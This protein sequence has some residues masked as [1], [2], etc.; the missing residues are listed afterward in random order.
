MNHRPLRRAI[1]L[2]L[3]ALL[4]LAGTASADRLFADGDALTP[5]IEG[6]KHLGDVSPGAEV[7]VDI[8]FVLTCIGN[9]HVDDGQSVVLSANGG[10]Q[11]GDGLIVEVTTAVLDPVPSGWADDGGGCPDPVP[12]LPGGAVSR[13][14]LR[15]PTAPGIGYSFTVAWARSFQPAGNGDSLALG[16]SMTSI[17]LTMN[18][19][20]NIAPRL[21]LPASFSVEGNAVNGWTADWSGVLAT[22]PEDAPDP[23]PT[24]TPASGSTLPLGTNHVSCSVT[25]SG[26]LTTTGGFDVTVVDTTDPVL[27]G[28]PADSEVITSDPTGTTLAFSTPTAT[29]V[30]DPSP[31]VACTPATGDHVGTGTTTVTCT[32]TDASGNSATDTFDVTVT[33]RAA[34]TASATW[35]DPIDV[36]G[37]T[38]S[39]NHGRTLPIKVRLFVDG[40]EVLGGSAS[41]TVTPCG[42]GTGLELPLV[43]GGGRWNAS[44]DTSLLVG[45]CHTVTAWVQALEA[46]SFRLELRGAEPTRATNS[47]T[48][49][50]SG[51]TPASTSDSK[52]AKVTEPKSP[53]PD[54]AKPEKAKDPKPDKVGKK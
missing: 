27:A 42:G 36:S 34:H 37:N 10:I 26:G 31:D 28:V 4:A 33:F 9:S 21:V 7:S 16:Q 22:D 24:C 8:S 41:L 49:P 52:P 50:T 43:T 6:T 18:V 29:D 53:G 23:I 25:D 46:G 39:T 20:G 11:P 14:T 2:S 3:G 48:T 15:A 32:A 13:V 5:T 45:S 12:S 40:T 17:N 35:Q 1:A 38:F 19:V 44:L 30:V 54:T 47:P 51:A